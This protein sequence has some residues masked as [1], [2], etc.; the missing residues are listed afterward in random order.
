MKFPIFEL[1][2]SVDIRPLPGAWVSEL[3]DVVLGVQ[4]HKKIKFLMTT[5]VAI[6]SLRVNARV[7]LGKKS[8]KSKK[9]A[10]SLRNSKNSKKFRLIAKKSK[11]SNT[12]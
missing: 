11:K 8:K 2:E 10:I 9:L 5:I 12:K 4:D 1:S 7:S 3:L 6:G